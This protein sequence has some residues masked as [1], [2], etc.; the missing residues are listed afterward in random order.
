MLLN[1]ILTK[2]SP[3]KFFLAYYLQLSLSGI[4]FLTL[5]N[6]V[7]SRKMKNF[8]NYNISTV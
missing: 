8:N 5:K 7:K 3:I 4:I 1:K 2:I 6:A